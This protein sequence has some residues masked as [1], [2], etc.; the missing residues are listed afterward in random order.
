M[1]QMHMSERQPCLRGRLERES[2]FSSR[3][4]RVWIGGRSEN[5]HDCQFTPVLNS[6]I[7]CSHRTDYQDINPTGLCGLPARDNNFAGLLLT[8]TVASS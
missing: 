4:R 7:S 1:G 8:A 2:A 3:V 6:S 5:C